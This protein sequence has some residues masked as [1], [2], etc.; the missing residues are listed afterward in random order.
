[1]QRSRRSKDPEA[2]LQARFD[3]DREASSYGSLTVAGIWNGI[4]PND[5]LLDG[6]IRDGPLAVSHH[7][8]KRTRHFEPWLIVAR[9]I[10]ISMIGGG[11]GPNTPAL[12][13]RCLDADDATAH[14]RRVASLDCD[15]QPK[16]IGPKTK[17]DHAPVQGA[18]GLR[19]A[20]D[21][22]PENPKCRAVILSTALLRHAGIWSFRLRS[23][24]TGAPK[25]CTI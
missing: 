3:P 6:E 14:L 17:D 7:R 11:E 21:R 5:P 1:M 18:Q 13:L 15:G 2:R 22:T 10:G 12:S 20:L 16:S 19:F 8:S 24:N 25:R 4:C 9:V 23:L